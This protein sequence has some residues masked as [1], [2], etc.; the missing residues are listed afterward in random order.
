MRTFST[1]FDELHTMDTV[2]GTMTFQADR[3]VIE[4]LSGLEFMD[5][6]PGYAIYGRNC[7]KA[8]LVFNNVSSYKLTFCPY[9]KTP[10]EGGFGPTQVESN[11]WAS[12]GPFCEFYLEGVKLEPPSAWLSLELQAQSFDL[13]VQD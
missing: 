1:H 6:H 4:I 7:P 10:Q 11:Q 2:Y 12:A 3:T 5:G 13:Q 9:L 8:E